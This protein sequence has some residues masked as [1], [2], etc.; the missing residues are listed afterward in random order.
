MYLHED[1]SSLLACYTAGPLQQWYKLHSITNNDVIQ[2]TMFMLLC[3]F[4]WLHADL[5]WN[6]VHSHI[7][8]CQNGRSSPATQ[9]QSA[10]QLDA[11]C[12]RHPA[13]G[14][15]AENGKGHHGPCMH[16]NSC[17]QDPAMTSADTIPTTL[18]EPPGPGGA[19]T[20]CKQQLHACLA[21]PTF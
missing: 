9:V 6:G 14:T 4:T 21:K 5:P 19:P 1:H 12:V 15:I 7:M 8:H 10:R 3:L 2:T 16:V 18:L 20:S 11:H 13:A 17:T